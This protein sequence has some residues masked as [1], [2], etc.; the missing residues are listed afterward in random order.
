MARRHTERRVE[1]LRSGWT[2]TSD[3]EETLAAM[4][5][6]PLLLCRSPPVLKRL[7]QNVLSIHPQG[8]YQELVLYPLQI[9]TQGANV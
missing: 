6:P 4:F 3:L 2:S 5:S 1:R 7:I 9:C 8:A